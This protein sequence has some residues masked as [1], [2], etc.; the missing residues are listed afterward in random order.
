MLAEQINSKISTMESVTKFQ[1]ILTN[2]YH[3]LKNEAISVVLR[4]EMVIN[5]VFNDLQP[6]ITKN[7]DV[8][9][10]VISNIR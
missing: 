1:E 10:K 6:Y 7:T 8:T 9:K 4:S 2:E 5:G 3:N